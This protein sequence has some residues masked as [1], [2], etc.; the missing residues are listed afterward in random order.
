MM[1]PPGAPGEATMATPRVMM[2]GTTVARLMGSWF[3]RQTAVAQA[4]MVIMEPVSYT[5]L[6]N[7]VFWFDVAGISD[8]SNF[9]GNTGVYGQ[10]GMYMTGF[11]P[12]MMFGLPAACLAMYQTAKPSK[13]KMVYGLLASAA[14]CSFFTGVTEPIEF[15]FMFLAPGLYAVSYTHLE[16]A[17]QAVKTIA[18]ILQK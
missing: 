5:H 4:V 1:D 13:K 9:W 15:S 10:T 11:F 18:Q 16:D 6:L 8:L 3:I 7:S 2:N 12:F 17:E 14:F